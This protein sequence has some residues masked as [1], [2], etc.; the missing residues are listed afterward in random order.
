MYPRAAVLRLGKVNSAIAFKIYGCIL[1]LEFKALVKGQP[2][3]ISNKAAAMFG[4]SRHQKYKAFK[5]LEC[6]GL[7]QV[8]RS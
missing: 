8:D 1:E 2:I 7:I 5:V 4:V 3:T 6:L